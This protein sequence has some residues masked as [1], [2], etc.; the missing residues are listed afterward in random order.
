MEDLKLGFDPSDGSGRW[1]FRTTSSKLESDSICWSFG[2][3]VQENEKVQRCTWLIASSSFLEVIYRPRREGLPFYT[4]RNRSVCRNIASC[5]G[6]LRG[7]EVD[8]SD[9][10]LDADEP[11]GKDTEMITGSV[12]LQKEIYGRNDI[13]KFEKVDDVDI[14]QSNINAKIDSTSAN[15]SLVTKWKGIRVHLRS[16]RRGYTQN[17][18]KSRIGLKNAVIENSLNAAKYKGSQECEVGDK[19]NQEGIEMLTPHT[20]TT[21]LLKSNPAEG[22]KDPGDHSSDTGMDCI[23]ITFALPS[24]QDETCFTSQADSITPPPLI[25]KVDFPL[26]PRIS[27]EH[28]TVL[29]GDLSYSERKPPIKHPSHIYINGWQSW[30]FSGSVARGDPQPGSAMPDYLSRAFN[31]GG[32]CP[33]RISPKRTRIRTSSTSNETSSLA[34]SGD[35]VTP[36]SYYKSEMYTALTFNEF[37]QTFKE[38]HML[39]ANN[40]SSIILGW[41]SQRKQFGMIGVDESL[42]KVA[43]HC[44][45]DGIVSNVQTPL[46]TDQFK[47]KVSI[48]SRHKSYPFLQRERLQTDWAWCQIIHKNSQPIAPPPYSLANL[49]SSMIQFEPLSFYIDFVA[50]YNQARHHLREPLSTGWCSWYHYYENLDESTLIENFETLQQLNARG[51]G[52]NMCMC[53]DG[54]MSAWGDWD[55]IKPPNKFP[56]QHNAMKKISNGM[57]DRSMRPGVWLAPFAAD[58]HSVIAQQHPEWIIRNHAGVAANSANCGKF[59]YGLDATNPAVLEHARRSI[60]R[61]VKEWGY[62]VLKL[63]FLYSSCLEGNG[64]FDLSMVRNSFFTLGVF[65]YYFLTRDSDPDQSRSDE[66]RL[67]NCARRCWR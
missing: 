38:D 60:E 52:F 28:L 57:A 30:S 42:S 62:K 58:K 1:E 44:S 67:E 23:V 47:Y 55:S 15:I 29:N 54:Y 10:F 5:G 9:Y 59:F 12:G 41:I 32:S 48:D 31:F 64:K 51:V 45:C 16:H 27:L 37:F 6:R 11:D 8:D 13:L 2:Y 21:P 46:P 4:N 33:N 39:D 50:Q 61:A 17:H 36:P 66:H 18:P 7:S 3:Y 56:S 22:Y 53:D 24:V 34:P 49:G 14:G 65:I 25:W 35:A 26:D 19:S 20:S 40:T 63:D 43:M